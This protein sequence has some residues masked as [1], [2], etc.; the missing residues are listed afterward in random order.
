MVACRGFV[1]HKQGADGNCLFRSF[2]HQV[3]GSSNEHLT[4]REACATWIAARAHR[5]GAFIDHDGPFED[6]L[7]VIRRPGEWVGHIEIQALADKYK[8]VVEIYDYGSHT[9][10]HTLVG[11]GASFNSCVVRLEYADEQGAEHYNS[12]SLDGVPI[13]S[14]GSKQCDTFDAK[15]MRPSDSC[16]VQP[17]DANGVKDV[18]SIQKPIF[19]MESPDYFDEGRHATF[20]HGDVW[21][22]LRYQ[23]GHVHFRMRTLG[24]LAEYYDPCSLPCKCSRRRA[25]LNGSRTSGYSAASVKKPRLGLRGS[26]VR[27]D[28]TPVF[29]TK[30]RMRKEIGRLHEL[31]EE[32]TGFTIFILKVSPR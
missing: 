9:L 22:V 6:Y 28:A 30:Q 29:L 27:G 15:V 26:D 25:S 8:C 1:V 14:M 11:T 19:A 23:S 18:Y 12:L 24:R 5:Y 16:Q 31:C 17:Q 13:V 21:E 4:L 10:R 2:A 20:G 32:A 7:Q 3:C